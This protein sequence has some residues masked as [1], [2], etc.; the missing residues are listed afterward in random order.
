MD[1]N[2]VDMN[3]M[4]V[5]TVDVEAEVQ[6]PMDLKREESQWA[7]ADATYSASHEVPGSLKRVHPSPL[8]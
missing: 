8:P 4:D 3:P 7:Q 5:N 1:V 2:P 6:R